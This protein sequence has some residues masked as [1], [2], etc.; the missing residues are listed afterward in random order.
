MKTFDTFELIVTD[1][2]VAEIKFNQPEKHNILSASFWEDFPAALDY[3]DVS[4]SVR[5][6]LLTSSGK[7]FCAGMD[8]AFFS[9]VF[10][11]SQKEESGRF[12]EWLRREINRLQNV[13]NRLETIRIPVISVIQGGCIGGALDLICATNIR[14]CSADAYFSIH[15]TNVGMTADLGSLQRLPRLIPA[16]IAH[17]LAFSGRKLAADEAR[18]SGLVNQVFDT[19]GEALVFARKMAGLIAEKSPLAITGIKKSL[20]HAR[21][22]TVADGLEYIASWNAAMFINDDIGLAL[23][24]Q[25]RHRVADF[26]NLTA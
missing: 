5:V 11:K 9:S 8:L 13:I 12:R 14:Y 17:E 24:A 1:G 23:D 10:E 21:D 4:A 22:H 18:E 16:G 6:L 25:R 19:Q 20:H 7:N 2:T 15:E 3:L 26:K